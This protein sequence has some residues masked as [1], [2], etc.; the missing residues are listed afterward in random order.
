MIHLQR[1]AGAYVGSVFGAAQFYGTKK[2][3]A[4]EL[5]SKLISDQRDGDV[6]GPAGFE[7][8]VRVRLSPPRNLRSFV[9]PAAGEDAG[10]RGDIAGRPES[11][12]RRPRHPP[13]PWPAGRLSSRW[14]HSRWVDDPPQGAAGC[15]SASAR[16]GRPVPGC[17]PR[18]FP[19]DAGMEWRSPPSCVADRCSGRLRAVQ[20]GC[21]ARIGQA[22]GYLDQSV[23]DSIISRPSWPTSG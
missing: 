22:A 20:R 11:R 14:P 18:V 1:I 19:T 10:G 3:A 9:P 16:G 17:A 2:S 4:M 21:A 6:D 5:T 23:I 8:V 12:T 15:D 13:P 7:R